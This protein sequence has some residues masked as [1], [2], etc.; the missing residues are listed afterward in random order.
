MPFFLLSPS[1]PQGCAAARCVALL[2]AYGLHAVIWAVA[3][4]VLARFCARVPATRHLLLK[5]ALLGP[6]LT[7]AVSQTWTVDASPSSRKPAVV[8]QA[9]AAEAVAIAPVPAQAAP[10]VLFWT[11]GTGSEIALLVPVVTGL[12]LLGLL[13][14]A[15][16]LMLLRRALSRRTQVRDPRL[17]DRFSWLRERAAQRHAVL[18]ESPNA[19]CPFVF[20]RHEICVPTDLLNDF[21]DAEVD[22][23]F[24]HELAHLE[25]R[26]GLW[27]PIIGF[28]EAVF[29]IQPLNS[30]LSTRC[31]N[32]AELAA[33]DRAVELTGAPLDLARAL[34]R[35]AEV[36]LRQR[37]A[38]LTPALAGSPAIQLQRVTRLVDVV[39][40]DAREVRRQAASWTPALARWSSMAC[41]CGLAIALPSLR[42][43]VATGPQPT[44]AMAHAGRAGG[45]P[46]A[47]A[48]AEEMDALN[49]QV[50]ELEAEMRR[51]P[52]NFESFEP[53]A[54]RQLQLEQDLRHVRAIQAWK[55]EGFRAAQA[56]SA[57][58]R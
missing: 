36:S 14:F 34:T 54:Q 49:A 7:T 55:Q 44:A 46:E 32:A 24:A 37:D 25:R 13:R 1:G 15:A 26:D 22:A 35:M 27:F 17:A 30:W 33:D 42:A 45:A 11:L 23:V 9:R 8:A 21:S 58:N 43:V 57:R 39:K 50:W 40:P 31:R 3:A 2:L 10:S 18:T 20:G 56:A 47:A 29:W 38:R 5:V 4:L 51:S 52:T 53:E 41:L 6:L 48:H 28:V 19:P 12:C 16:S